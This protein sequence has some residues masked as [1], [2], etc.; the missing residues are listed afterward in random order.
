M[1]RGK[2]PEQGFTLIE[3]LVVVI[4]IGILA[5]IAI[6]VYLGQRK[7]AVDAS[8][9]SDLQTVVLAMETYWSD[10]QDYPTASGANVVSIFP[11]LKTSP[12][13]TVDVTVDATGQD[14]CL[15]ASAPSRASHSWVYDHGAGGLQPATVTS[16]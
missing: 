2:T 13:N 16:C 11:G 1:R 14:Y 12:G 8:L 3:L 10:N 5:A 4:I 9:K 15:I 6:P 7:K